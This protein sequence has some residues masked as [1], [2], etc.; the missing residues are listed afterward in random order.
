MSG[1]TMP[2]RVPT[3]VNPF[4]VKRYPRFS[5]DTFKMALVGVTL[6]PVRLVVM[7]SSLLIGVAISTLATLGHDESRP[8]SP[9]R[10]AIMQSLRVVAR[11]MLW[12]LGYWWISVERQPGSAP[13][14]TARVLAV[15]PHYSLIDPM[16]MLYL[17]LPCSVAKREVRSMPLIGRV[18]A[19]LQTIFV[20][21]KD[22]NSKRRTV[23]AIIERAKPGCAWPSVLV[24]PEGTCT[25][26]ECLITFKPGAFMPGEPVQ[27]VVLRYP[28]DGLS[29]SAAS[30]DCY[31]RLLYAML[32]VHNKLS[33]TY[34]PL[35]APTAAAG[36]TEAVDAPAFAASV[37][38]TMAA[39]LA[40]P[41]TSHS[42]ED[43]WLASKA[44]KYA[45]SQSF[46]VAS[47][48]ALFNL[49][50]DGIT[51]LLERFHAFD[52]TGDGQL[53]VEEFAEALS[54]QPGST[55]TA[56][57]FSFFDSDGSGSI[58]YAE[59]V[60]GVAVN[61]PSTSVEDKVKLAFLL[62]DVDGSGRVSL[63]NL[64][65][66][67]EHA[68]AREVSYEIT[69]AAAEGDNGEPP[70]SSPA[71]ASP[72][73]LTRTESKM[74]AAFAKHDLDG[75]HSLS[76][77]EFRTFLKE[78]RDVL[79]LSSGILHEKLSQ[80]NLV[81]PIEGT[82]EAALSKIKGERVE[83]SPEKAKPPPAGPSREAAK[84]LM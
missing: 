79:E 63:A 19:A 66:I 70:K 31:K 45:V 47:L 71:A 35:Q 10:R 67:I 78:Y 12:S 76:L 17:E 82:I 34:L 72:P 36:A 18:T 39:H 41:V 33:V 43:V 3:T 5:S 24:F 8:L 54:L 28:F 40:V 14:G 68:R 30:A 4:K 62:M 55:H 22:K 81:Q 26:G 6:F 21:R 69:S 38:A 1:I 13:K 9:W 65:D 84:E 52:T 75:S 11:A 53:S 32:Q 44:A 60:Q 37:R 23:E 15:A 64:K 61:S 77:S 74:E 16:V 25:N 48:Q 2:M 58:S 29:V 83:R 51:Q 42:Y 56:Q 59:F 27:P 73:F 80:A 57:L 50:T 7:S 46:E 20:D 49:S